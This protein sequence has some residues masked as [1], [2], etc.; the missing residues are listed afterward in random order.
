MAKNKITAQFYK[1]PR[2]YKEFSCIG[3]TCPMSCCLIWRVDWLKDEYEKLKNAECSEELRK[4][5]DTS[6]RDTEPTFKFKIQLDDDY[7]SGELVADTSL[8][9]NAEKYLIKMNKNRCP[10][11][12]EDNFCAIQRELGEE[13]LSRTCRI[14]PRMSVLRGNT[15]YRYCNLSCYRIMDILCND[16][17]CMILENLMITDKKA[18]ALSVYSSTDLINHPEYKYHHQLLE[19]FYDILSDDSHSIETSIVLG[20]LAA[21]G[22]TRIIGNGE[23]DKIPDYMKDIKNQL[24]DPGQIEKL[25]TFKPKPEVRA[26][27]GVQLDKSIVNSNMSSFIMD[28]DKISIDKFLDGDRKFNEDYSDRPFALR[29]I[30]LNLLLELKLPFRDKNASLFENYCYFAAAVSAIKYVAACVYATGKD[31]DNGF[32]TVS[33]FVSRSFAHNDTNIKKIIEL[34]NSY[35]CTSPAYLLLILK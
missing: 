30:A 7:K 4:L 15:I 17:D 33:A 16:K 24:N 11:L 14:Y 3:G 25:E 27:F 18:D 5:I 31:T 9:K 22:L 21:Q 28:D 34:L 32:K 1:Q 8:N 20:A 2:Y 6:F 19:F 13:Y 35:H 10:F 23:Y 12:T 26:G 29:N